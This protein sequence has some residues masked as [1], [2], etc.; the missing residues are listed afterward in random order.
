MKELR[1]TES[2]RKSIQKLKR[3]ERVTSAG[4]GS[5]SSV[6]DTPAS[7]PGNATPSSK[8]PLYLSIS[9]RGV[10]F[11]DIQTEVLHIHSLKS[12]K[13][14]SFSVYIFFSQSTICE[15]EIR[16]IDC[17]CQDSD[18][19]SHFAYITKDSNLNIHYCHVFNVDS[20]VSSRIIFNS[21]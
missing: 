1:G 20:M 2:T 21:T 9:H 14:P 15:H 12:I 18:D 11:I 10:Q 4:G 5:G 16:N 17:A 8:R 7:A 19:L 6:S 3:E 13:V